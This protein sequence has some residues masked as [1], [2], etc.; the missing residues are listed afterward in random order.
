MPTHVARMAVWGAMV[1]VTV[2]GAAKG[3]DALS[4]ERIDEAIGKG[5]EYLFSS[6]KRDGMWAGVSAGL[7]QPNGP[8]GLCTYA[9]LR[10]GVS[11]RD[12]RIVRA[13]QAME[14]NAPEKTYAISTY[15][16]ALS[17]AVRQGA[18]K[19]RKPL[20]V[21]VGRLIRGTTR[22]GAYTYTLEAERGWDFSNTNYGFFGVWIG[23]RV[24]GEVPRDYWV[25]SATRWLDYQLDDGAWSYGG[26]LK[27]PRAAMTAAGAASLFVCFDHLRAEQFAR[28]GRDYREDPIY[29]G[30]DRALGWFER[31]FAATMEGK[32]LHT[33]DMYY[34]LYNVERVGLASGYKYFGE[35]DWFK[36]GTKWLLSKQ[37][38][39]GS[40]KGKWGRDE[41][42]AFA[43]LFLA[44][45]RAPIMFNKLQYDGDWNN[46][47]RDCAYVTRWV[48][49][50]FE[51]NVNWQ[52]V[53]LDVEAEDWHDAPIVYIAGSGSPEFSEE[54]LDK[55]RTFVHQGGTILSV[56][57]CRGAAFGRQ[58]G[59]VYKKLFPD[60][61]LTE[62][63][64]DHELYGAQFELRGRPRFSMVTNGVRPLAI[65][66]DTDLARFWQLQR[67]ETAA[68]A[69]QAAANVYFYVTDKYFR[70][71]GEKTWPDEP[72]SD[73]RGT[74]KVAR[75]A[76]EGNCNPEPLAWERFARLMGKRE[77]WAVD[78]S[79]PVEIAKLAPGDVQVA[80]MTGTDAFE[81]GPEQ[82][83]RLKQFVMSGGTL[84]IDAAG[85]S[86]EF[87]E[88]VEQLCS[89]I[90]GPDAFQRLS[91][92]APLY[93]LDGHVIDEVSYRRRVR[94]RGA[95]PAPRLKTIPVTGRPAVLYSSYDLTTGLAGA[96]AYE[97]DGY[98]AES[99]Y[100]IMRNVILTSGAR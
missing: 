21:L 34:Y 10:A 33:S 91:P 35:Q 49:P 98:T 28:C 42:T 85:G 95:P 94:V 52:I 48:E 25:Q 45:G 71:R 64:P 86:R 65:H 55:L 11:V 15:V 1:I 30:I 16:S 78:V 75:L 92:E 69:F 89:Q 76:H 51:Q 60:Y 9:L 2:T 74:T 99:A 5:V 81:L 57:E 83:E 6:Q 73:A 77:S 63:G 100:E 29:R 87:A 32:H 84:V 8:T 44:Q 13:L 36:E 70:P 38:E 23:Q 4:V 41:G 12:E 19:Y 59:R 14:R 40:W 58:M 46:R 79:G 67:H 56:T 50:E 88:S 26:I 7:G 93:Q 47:P 27:R 66:T 24:L 3:E 96:S 62:C 17:E 80:V 22:P 20:R 37:Q 43:I 39:D 18:G 97:C 61:E 54:D 68:W 53:N 82:R 90:W 31:N 72:T